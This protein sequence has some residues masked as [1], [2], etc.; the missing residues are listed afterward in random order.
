MDDPTIPP[1]ADDP[2]SPTGEGASTVSELTL[3]TM[4]TAI[5]TEGV[6]DA[7]VWPAVNRR[8]SRPQ[9]RRSSP[10]R[11]RTGLVMAAA[12]LVVAGWTL[13]RPSVSADMSAA[14]A[15]D[16][17]RNDPQV[18]A[19]L[20]GDILMTTVTSVVNDLATVVV[21]DNYGRQVV[22]SVDLRS[23]IVSRVYEGQQLSGPMSQRAIDLVHADPRTSALLIRGATLG[24]ITPVEI[25]FVRASPTDGQS[26]AGTAIGARVPLDLDGQEWVATLDLTNANV[27]Q[28]VDPSGRQVTSP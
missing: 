5:A 8:V 23:R 9:P 21:T 18:A 14:Q 11:L 13:I 17:A 3:R 24:Q 20:R 22:V 12:L 2:S 19:L 10:V 16:L 26:A 27:D 25:S 1:G 7:D 4:L 15:G 28:L 6:P